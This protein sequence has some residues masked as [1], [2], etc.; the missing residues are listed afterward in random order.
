M[1]KLK[2]FIILISLIFIPS[3]V[4]AKGGN[5]TEGFDLTMAL[6]NGSFCINSYVNFCIA[7]IIK[8]NIKGKFKKDVLDFVWNQNS[9]FAIF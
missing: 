1:K 9:H 5:T 3:M 6:R 4:F 7:T 2:K 8:I